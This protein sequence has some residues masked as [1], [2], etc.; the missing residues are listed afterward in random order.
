MENTK[1]DL[2]YGLAKVD[3][4]ALLNTSTYAVR[5][6]TERCSFYLSEIRSVRSAHHPEDKDMTA[7]WLN[8]NWLKD[9]SSQL[10]VACE[11]YAT[12]KGA[13]EDRGIEIINKP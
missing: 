1:N 3:F 4:Q 2:S 11:T 12:L 5:E 7:L 13:L 9:V 6:L 10:A 8:A